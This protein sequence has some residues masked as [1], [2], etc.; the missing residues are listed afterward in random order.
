VV[1][2]ENEGFEPRYVYRRLRILFGFE[3]GVN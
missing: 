3:L 2:D 1:G